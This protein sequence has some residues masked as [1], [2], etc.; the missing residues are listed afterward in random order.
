MSSI[1]QLVLYLAHFVHVSLSLFS[2]PFLINQKLFIIIFLFLINLFV[3]YCFILLLV[4]TCQS[5]TS[6]LDA[7]PSDTNYFYLPVDAQNVR[8]FHSINS[9]QHFATLLSYFNSVYKTQQDITIIVSYGQYQYVY[10]KLY[11][12]P[13]FLLLIPS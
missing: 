1:L 8:R 2:C 11:V 5:T 12:Y 7:V 3:M 4:V 10:Y 13:L 9:F 6:F